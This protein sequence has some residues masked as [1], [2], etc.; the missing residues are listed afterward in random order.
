MF[1]V[2]LVVITPNWKLP[3]LSQTEGKNCGIFI[4]QLTTWQ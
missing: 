4:Q 2:D 3:E 1:I